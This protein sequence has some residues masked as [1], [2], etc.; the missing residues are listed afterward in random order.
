MKFRV[1]STSI[2]G[3]FRDNNEDSLFVDAQNRFF[4]VADGMGG[5]SAGERASA[6]A[7][8]VIPKNCQPDSVFELDKRACGQSDRRRHCAG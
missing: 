3:N 2:K 4:L 8:E 5:Q 7:M 1:G 6:L